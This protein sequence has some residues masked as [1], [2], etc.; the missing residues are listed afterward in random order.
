MTPELR[1]SIDEVYAA[2]ADVRKPDDIVVCPCCM[3]PTEV[4]VL[5][6]KKL[7]ELTPDEL[8]KYG[9]KVFNTVGD[10]PDF[11]YFLPRLLEIVV[12]N[13]DWWPNPEVLLPKLKKAGFLD[14]PERRCAA[15]R[16]F[17]EVAFYDVMTR[18]SSEWEFDSWICALGL[19][20]GDV[21]PYLRQLENRPALFRAYY[22]ENSE[23]LSKGNL[24]NSFWEE[25]PAAL[26]QVL[27]W[28]SSPK[29][30]N[31]IKEVY[32]L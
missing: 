8:S 23:C 19:F 2:F 21:S 26:R 32:G 29:I 4:K 22:E 5:L 10:I 18:A 1:V 11:L 6:S 14:W 15:V 7:K 16:N 25:N 24:T 20:F 13:P 28:F 31:M 17:L 30:K 12:T 27:D 9:S 3:E